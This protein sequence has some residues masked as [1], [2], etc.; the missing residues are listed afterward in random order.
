[1]RSVEGRDGTVNDRR[2]RT[3]PR[4]RDHVDPEE[5]LALHRRTRTFL[6]KT[7]ASPP[8]GPTVV[9][10]HHA[11]HPDS[12]PDHHGRLRWCDASDLRDL[13]YARGPSH[14]VHGHIHAAAGYVA[15]PTR[16]VCSS[17]G[18]AE[19]RFDFVASKAIALSCLDTRLDRPAFGRCVGLQPKR[20]CPPAHSRRNLAT[21]GR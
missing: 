5:L 4:S 17:R 21:S 20:L 18:H 12:L 9:V 10:T 14:L 2:I 13:I 7:V 8:D 11:P 15:G 6:D 16:I 1:M 3:G 19:E